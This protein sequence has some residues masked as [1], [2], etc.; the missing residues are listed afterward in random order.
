MRLRTPDLRVFPTI[1]TAGCQDPSPVRV[2]RGG[3]TE[4]RLRSLGWVWSG[5][6]GSVCP[7]SCLCLA[8]ASGS[9]SA[10][11]PFFLLSSHPLALCCL[12]HMSD[13]PTLSC[14]L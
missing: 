2:Q 8:V 4:G 12:L 9:L 1:L 10:T 14:F 6:P 5:L 3:G 11:S 13:L 7:V